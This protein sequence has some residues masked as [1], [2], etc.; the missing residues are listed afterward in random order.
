MSVVIH[1][2][3][4]LDL[5]NNLFPNYIFFKIQ[6]VKHTIIKFFKINYDNVSVLEL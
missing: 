2:S 5:L 1:K 6:I 4:K 3:L